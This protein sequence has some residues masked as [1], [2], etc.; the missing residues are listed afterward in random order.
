MIWLILGLLVF[1]GVHSIRALAPAWREARIES[2]G[3]RTWKLVFSVVSIAGF[4]LLLWGYGQ[5]R[6][7][8]SPLLWSPP[9]GLR[10]LASLLTLPAFVLLVAAYVPRNHFKA[11]LGHPMTLAV[12]LWALA[13]LL[14]NGAL[15][16]VLLFGGFLLW[17]V[18]VFRAA[19]RRAPAPGSGGS[20]LGTT[21]SLVIGLAA[22]AAFAF[23]LHVRW[24]GVPPFAMS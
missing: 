10:H 8:G 17:A 3:E 5:A 23:Y 24:I 16:D 14:V 7:E 2:M 11:R 12:K 13:H 19:R 20:A 18:L 9:L 6:S 4:V 1:L 15:H 21:L 22:W